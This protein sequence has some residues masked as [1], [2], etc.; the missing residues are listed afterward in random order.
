MHFELLVARDEIS[1]TT[2]LARV[3]ERIPSSAGNVEDHQRDRDRRGEHKIKRPQGVFSRAVQLVV[4]DTTSLWNKPPWPHWEDSKGEG[5]QIKFNDPSKDG[6]L[7]SEGGQAHNFEGKRKQKRVHLVILTHGLHSNLSADLL[8]LKESIDATASEAREAAR[9][10]RAK[11]REQKV[12]QQQTLHGREKDPHR[13]A[14]E[15][16]HIRSNELE[17]GEEE[18][19]EEVVVRGFTENVTRTERGI[20]Y[21]GKRLAKYILHMTYPQQPF[22]PV[23]GPSSKTFGSSMGGRSSLQTKNGHPAHPHSSLFEQSSSGQ[24]LPYEITSISFIGH[25]L[26]GL[27]QTYAIAY[28]QKHSPHFFEIIKP[29]NFIA[30]ATPFLG[31]SNENPLYVKFA[32]DFGL[33]GRTGQDL[34]LVWRAPA[35]TRTGLGAFIA[36]L[37]VGAQKPKAKL[38][39]PGSKPLLRILPTGPAHTALKAFRKRTVYAN[40]VNDGIVP[41]RTSCLLFLDWGSLERVEKAR[42]ENG[43]VGIMAE[44]GWAELTGSKVVSRNERNHLQDASTD[45]AVKDNEAP[46]IS[47]QQADEGE[48]PQPS[49]N[50]A[51][52]DTAQQ[53]LGEPE[54]SRFLGNHVEPGKGGAEERSSPPEFLNAL[55]NF[56]NIFLPNR[57]K[58]HQQPAKM[59]KVY[60][61]SQT[62]NGNQADTSSEDVPVNGAAAPN[63]NQGKPN[64]TKGEESGSLRAPPTTSFF[65]SASALLSP[66]VPPT[67]FLIDPSSRPRTIFH[68][69]VYHPSDIPP[70]PV[71]RRSTFMRSLSGSRESTSTSRSGDSLSDNQKPPNAESGGMTV[72]EK[73]ARA[74]HRDMSWRKVLV[75]LEPDAHNNIIVR[76]MFA[77]AYGWPVIKHLV[78]THFTD[79]DVATTRDDEAS[80]IE[81]AKDMNQG[82]GEDGEE[83]NHGT[84]PKSPQNAGYTEEDKDKVGELG[85]SWNQNA[86]SNRHPGMTRQDSVQW[87]DADFEVTDDEDD[88]DAPYEPISSSKGGSHEAHGSPGRKRTKNPDPADSLGASPKSDVHIDD[89]THVGLRR[90]LDRQNEDGVMAQVAKLAVAHHQK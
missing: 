26:G 74:Y 34:G 19:D 49:I 24:K 68:D 13:E 52:D 90:A 80:G 82:V 14:I 5:S 61:R 17:P 37:G 76:R 48:V 12:Q 25:S 47:L 85:S 56:L 59:S 71:K 54:P 15:S 18:T 77:N 7:D 50:A 70:M 10:R 63:K 22:L 58:S 53:P 67:E 83:V 69:R 20:K 46:V 55:N 87:S 1:L 30:L 11:Q 23:R 73:I 3:A 45:N 60:R 33:V 44:W 84:A 35:I 16:S 72:E 57:E 39:N 4:D 81:H 27:V 62:I 31:L 89:A 8:Y 79:T 9:Q 6:V 2:D 28:L 21:L 32:L 41:L 29:I 42:R 75:R 38:E 36:G 65:E 88:M 64:V 43:L 51:K 40:V 78:D 66:P 86:S